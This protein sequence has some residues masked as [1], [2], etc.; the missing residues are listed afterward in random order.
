MGRQP[1]DAIDGD[2]Y[3]V[4]IRKTAE[5][6]TVTTDAKLMVSQI[7]PYEEREDV[8]ETRTVQETAKLPITGDSIILFV[9]LAMV[10]IALII[11]F[12]RM[13]KLDKKEDK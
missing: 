2:Q 7:T 13:K 10:V 12:V 4:L 11:V 1:S 9:A 6:G 8:E 3:V 5:D